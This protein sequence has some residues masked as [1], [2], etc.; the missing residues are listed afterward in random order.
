MFKISAKSE[1]VPCR[2]VGSYKK[3]R[4]PH[5]SST[6]YSILS[7]DDLKFIDEHLLPK[8]FVKLILETIIKILCASW[9]RV[10]LPHISNK[11]C[12]KIILQRNLLKINR[13]FHVATEIGSTFFDCWSCKS[14]ISSSFVYSKKIRC[15]QND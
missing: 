5:Y 4:K 1:L 3:L 8:I 9:A 10:N 14:G 7:G 6:F 12:I 15:A 2:L 13:K 11:K